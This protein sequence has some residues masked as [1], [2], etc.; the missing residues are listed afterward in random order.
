MG[1]GSM[2]WTRILVVVIGSTWFFPVSCAASLYSA[3]RVVA[4]LDARDVSRGDSLHSRFS[5]V[6]EPGSDGE[7]FQVMDL[8]GLRR[9]Q[10]EFN[11]R[12]S[13]DDVSF[14]MSKSD[15]R[16]E[17]GTSSYSYQVLED[18]GSEQLIEVVEAYHDGDNRIW[19]R[20]RATPF[21]ITPISSRMLYFG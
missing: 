13:A 15:G 21:T 20:Y 1:A 3:V 5:M 9:I 12:D 6:I 19:S 17:R 11:G 18:T 4:K 2:K 14:L 16:L 10:K 8:S 7:P